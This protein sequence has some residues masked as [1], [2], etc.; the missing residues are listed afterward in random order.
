MKKEIKYV[1]FTLFR[2]LNN[3]KFTISKVSKLQQQ[4]K[5][6]KIAVKVIALEKNNGSSVM[7]LICI[8]Y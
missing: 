3:S 5:F 6:I 8:L 7:D 1:G 2:R 4:Q